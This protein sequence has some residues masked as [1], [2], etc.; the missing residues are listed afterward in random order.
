MA[1]EVIMPALGMAQETGRI[2]SW[3]KQ[4]GDAVKT[5]DALMEVETDKAVM[6]VEAVADG[7]LVSVSAA[8]GQEVPVGQVIATISDSP[9]ALPP[10]AP[11]VSTDAE[12][13]AGQSII[14]PAL[15]MAQETGLVV[16]WHK[17]PGDK[18]EVEDVLFEVETDKSTVEVPAGHAGFIVA[19][20]AEAGQEV[21]VGDV[22]AIV[23]AT[24]PD[25]PFQAAAVTRAAEPVKELLLA[26]TLAEAAVAT[27]ITSQHPIVAH[28]S[29]IFASPKTRRLAK[30]QGLDLGRL[31]AAGHPQPYHV[32]DLEI[33]RNLPQTGINSAAQSGALPNQI[34]ARAPRQ[35][36]QEFLDWMQNEGKI[37]LA[38][39]ALWAAF[40]VAALRDTLQ[41]NGEPL[42]VTMMDMHG[43]SSTLT[44]PDRARLSCQ[45]KSDP[46]TFAD[47]I[48]RDLSYS[49]ITGMRL[50][51]SAQPS[52]SIAT[53]GDDYQISLEFTRNQFSETQA[54]KFIT[55]FADRLTEPLRQL[56]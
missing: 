34:T 38:P 52:L 13:P 42:T 51:G 26:A 37:T 28:G 54:I 21:P 15:G 7:Y 3:L 30:E 10:A 48:L 56:L 11:A 41:A 36:T 35:G 45:P 5:G 8:A 22:I 43:D 27:P 20:L 18:V 33:L 53:V 24:A 23:S 39:S 25:A 17:M 49:P 2:V 29:G 47:L 32:A 4:P 14:M 19:L 55:G 1:H 16:A 46:E 50:E 40:A 31:V 6:E 9:D 44:D 12:I